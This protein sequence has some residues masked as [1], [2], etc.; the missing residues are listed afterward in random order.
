MKAVGLKKYGAID[1]LE[2]LEVSKPS[3]PQG[4]DI[5][6]QVRACSVNPIDIKVRAEKYDDY[7][8]YYDHVPLNTDK[9][10]ILGYDSSGIIEQVG[11]GVSRFKVGDEVYFLASPFRQGSNADFV[12]V[13]ERTI[14]HKPRTLS[15]EQAAGIPLT[16]LT[17]WEALAERLE[18][19]EGEQVAILIINGAGGVGSIASQ[20]CAQIL[21]LPVIITTASRDETRK[22]TKEMGA[23]HVIDHHKN[24]QQQIAAL[25]LNVPLKYAF[26]THTPVGEYVKICADVL[27]PFG[28]MCSIVQGEFDMYGT[29]SMAKCLTFVWELL[30][31]KVRYGGNLEV[32]GE[33]L[34]KLAKLID[35][36][37]IK[38]IVTKVF[39]FN[40]ENLKKV[41]DMITKGQVIGKITLKMNS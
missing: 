29:P 18:I 19:K 31:T 38:S 33:F 6:I 22:F 16:A 35:E 1:V 15:F 40:C 10:Q 26:I 30:S 13:D 37:K 25:Q 5:L 23:T 36:G 17:A 14:A 9:Y 11:S 34:E 41:H 32:L 21:H 8:D 28:K 39:D 24:I 2:D 4:R 20:I 27:A 12:L 3:A 7:P